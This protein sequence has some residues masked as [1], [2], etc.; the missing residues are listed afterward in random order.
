MP[1]GTGTQNPDG[2][3]YYKNL[4]SAL[5]DANIKPMVYDK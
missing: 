5:K 4:I 1:N 2:I 3:Q